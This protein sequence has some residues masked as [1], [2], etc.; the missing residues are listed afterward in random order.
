MPV[1][2][3]AAADVE[4]TVRNRYSEG[5]ARMQPDLCC[6]SSCDP[7]YL[8]AIPQEVLERDYGCGN[9]TPYLK[10][11]E[12]VLDLGSGAGKLCFVA[13]QVVGPAGKVIGIDMNDD[14]LAVA[15]RNAPLVAQRLGYANVEFRKGRIQDLSLDLELLDRHLAT[16]P[17]SCA[18]ELGAL[19]AYAANLRR[20]APLVESDSVDVVISSCVLNL[21]KPDQKRDLFA[22][23][24]RVLR[25]GG[26]AIVSDIVSD[27]SVPQH[28]QDDPE[29]WSGCVS[30]ALR[31][32]SFL[33]AFEDTGFYGINICERQASPWRTVE[34]IE[35]RS[36]TVAA[37]KGKQGPCWDQQQAVIYKGPFQQVQDDD[38]HILKRGLR[39]AVCEKTFALYSREPYCSHFE[40]IEPRTKPA[41]EDAPAFPC[42]Q[43]M[44]LRDPRAT[45][46]ADY[47]LTTD[48]D[49]TPCCTDGNGANGCC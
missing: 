41:L 42:T 8:A 23:I 7:A 46:G 12:A 48:A 34:G 1:N 22:E 11:G 35:F 37:Y 20:T 21:V 4:R 28:L 14:M 25:K 18:E 30:G 38:G 5:A 43:G 15:R 13:A 31:E 10:E 39:V 32:D 16:H 40:L 29:L 9:P 33:Q 36:M 47:R 45:K 3:S 6:P 19:D 49:A 27:E 17:V 2:S 26:R 24:F 44:L